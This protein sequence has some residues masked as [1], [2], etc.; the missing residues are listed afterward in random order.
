MLRLNFESDVYEAGV[1]DDATMVHGGAARVLSGT[2]RPGCLHRMRQ[3]G[4][5]SIEGKLSVV[6]GGIELMTD[7]LRTQVRDAGGAPGLSVEFPRPP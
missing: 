7:W 4:E 2:M 3:A 5:V 1:S 6:P